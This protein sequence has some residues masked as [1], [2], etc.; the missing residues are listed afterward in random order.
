MLVLISC[1]ATRPYLYSGYVDGKLVQCMI[2]IPRSLK[3]DDSGT[4]VEIEKIVK[5]SEQC[6][7]N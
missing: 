5:E 3:L 1:T 6:E 7:K 2:E 4:K